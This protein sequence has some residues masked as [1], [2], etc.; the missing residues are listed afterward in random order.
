M[1]R[2]KLRSLEWTND[3]L[4]SDGDPV[5]ERQPLST[6][7]NPHRRNIGM[8]W[9]LGRYYT[10]S[11]RRG[12]RVVREYF[13]NGSTARLLARLDEI[14]RQQLADAANAWRKQKAEMDAAKLCVTEFCCNVELLAHSALI[15]AGFRK[16]RRGT[17]S[18]RHGKR[19]RT[20]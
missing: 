20:S 15:V 6:W 1:L 18:K 9:E 2:R 13:G 8:G 11:R 14:N 10:T 16:N 3:L 17:W 12:G 5:A 19:T 7:H 4:V